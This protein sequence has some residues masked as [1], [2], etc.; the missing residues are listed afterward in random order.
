MKKLLFISLLFLCISCFGQSI[1]IADL[2]LLNSGAV[3]AFVPGTKAGVTYKVSITNDTAA[4]TNESSELLTKNA[5]RK[6]NSG[7]TFSTS[8]SKTITGSWWFDNNVVA[9]SMSGY[10]D[11]WV[12]NSDGSIS[13]DNGGFVSDGTGNITL[14]SI[15]SSASIVSYDPDWNPVN[16]P[17]FAISNG[18]TQ[19]Q[20]LRIGYNNYTDENGNY[21][22]THITP[23]GIDGSEFGTPL[24][25]IN[26]GNSGAVIFDAGEIHSDG[27]GGLY[28]NSIGTPFSNSILEYDGTG[29]VGSNQSSG[30]FW[31]NAN[32]SIG[33]AQGNGNQ[34]TIEVNDDDRRVY[35]EKSPRNK[36]I[37]FDAL[38]GGITQLGLTT[39]EIN[40]IVSPLEGMYV[41]NSTLHTLCF[42]NGSSWQRL[43]S[44]GM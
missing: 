38:T 26:Q 39:I 9:N 5:A 37:T 34:T 12:L 7:G 25:S 2:P 10:A 23:Y 27:C 4:S 19:F 40:A 44:T 13:F 41:Y 11:N 24:W 30:M 20:D 33:D 43:S 36:T 31:A 16:L 29:W 18:Y 1:K 21:Y 8:A 6:L 42:F 35:I 17:S 14:N 15:T 32:T 22:N 3:G 28:V